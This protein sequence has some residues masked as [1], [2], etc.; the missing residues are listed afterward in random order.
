M[1]KRG[2]AGDELGGFADTAPQG[3]TV[4]HDF[5]KQAG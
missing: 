1:R 4:R 3:R 5:V 2:M